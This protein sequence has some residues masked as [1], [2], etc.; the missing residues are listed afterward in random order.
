MN[1]V[2]LTNARLVLRSEVIAGELRI[3]ADRVAAIDTSPCR[4]PG[5][6]DCDGDFLLPGLVELHADSLEKHAVPR[7]GVCWPLASAVIAH[8]AQLLCCGITTAFNAI[9]IGDFGCPLQP[10]PTVAA[11]NR[12]QE[13]GSLRVDHFLHL[14]CELP[15]DT[16]LQQLTPLLDQPTVR[17]LSL[18]D[19]TPGQRQFRD[20]KAYRRY[21]GRHGDRWD[22]AAFAAMIEERRALQR[23]NVRPNATALARLAAQRGTALASHDDASSEDVRWARSLGATIAEFPVNVAA[24]HAARAAGLVILGGAPNLVIGASHSGNVAMRDLARQELVDV[25]SSDYIPASLLS[26]AFLLQT[27]GDRALAHCVAAVSLLP[28]QA[29][30]LGDRG[31]LAVGKRADVLRVRLVQGEPSVQSAWVGGQQRF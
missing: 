17:L 12:A 1:E 10:T 29:V 20:L 6:I 5:A 7:P 19:H 31:E 8:D 23:Q 2:I 24:A 3:A 18:M 4:L 9:S 30:G 15:C 21:Y 13:S 14:R 28:A 25:L 11:I 16:L 26:A 27:L 22:D